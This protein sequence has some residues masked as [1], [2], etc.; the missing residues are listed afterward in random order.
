MPTINVEILEGRTLDQKRA[1]IKEI[2]DVITVA[3]KVPADAVSVRVQDMKFIDLENGD[4]S[5]WDFFQHEGKVLCSGSGEPRITIFCIEGRSLE[6]KR[7]AVRQISEKCAEI[8]G[9]SLGEVK[10]FINDMKKDQFSIGG[11]L[12]CDR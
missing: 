9:I 6:Q 7:E 3:F 4:E 8:L 1:L 12:I 2:C 10:V 5:Y 11:K